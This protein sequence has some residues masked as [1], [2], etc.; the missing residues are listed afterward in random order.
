M[1]GIPAEPLCPLCAGDSHLWAQRPGREL[2]RC[3]LC[4]FGW[5]REGLT[6]SANGRSIYEDDSSIFTDQEQSDYYRDDSALDAARDKLS[7]VA[8]HATPGERL[9]DVG[10]NVG[11]FARE[12]ARTFD[13][14][15][16]EP[17]RLTVDWGRSHLNS[18]ISLGTIE[19]DRSDFHSRFDLIT[20]F[21]V[22]EHLPDP[23]QALTHC[24]NY[25]SPGGRLFI[26]TPD[27]GS[28]M[29]RLLGS[30]WY[31]IDLVEHISLFNRTNLGRL[32]Q[33]A[34]FAV[35]NIRTIGRRYRCSYIERR[36]RQLAV[37]TRLLKAAHVAALPLKWVPQMRVRLNLGDVM[38]ITASR[39]DRR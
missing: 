37:D 9:L 31:Y 36:L 18:P 5:I 4:G 39:V 32:L 3:G 19:E 29:A 1:P 26:T 12:A 27:A 35:T 6:R 7:W 10:A 16:I 13:A 21:D 11:F 20:M 23:K 33:D 34:G 28:H 17:G 14:I 8:Q 15:G 25:L 22:I 2:R 30:H 24:W 38:G